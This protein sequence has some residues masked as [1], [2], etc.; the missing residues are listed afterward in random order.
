MLKSQN[1]RVTKARARYIKY[2]IDKRWAM[3]L[4]N[5]KNRIMLYYIFKPVFLIILA[6]LPLTIIYILTYLQAS[7]FLAVIIYILAGLYILGT[8]RTL[9]F[10]IFDSIF[11]VIENFKPIES[12]YYNVKYIV[13]QYQDLSAEIK[14]EL[15]SKQ[16]INKYFYKAINEA[17][18]L[19]ENETTC[20]TGC[21]NE[22]HEKIKSLK[23][24]ILKL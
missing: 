5:I 17:V 24:E 6:L 1:C 9:A 16:Y 20:K 15:Q 12:E 7:N 13:T 8:Y 21:L 2:N 23:N 3:T 18:A 4:Q 22:T 11:D 10:A 14:D 19:R